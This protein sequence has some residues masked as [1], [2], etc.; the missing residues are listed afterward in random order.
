[1]Y[2]EG[3]SW[4]HNWQCCCFWIEVLPG[5]SIPTQVKFVTRRPSS[6]MYLYDMCAWK[7]E[8]LKIVLVTPNLWPFVTFCDI[9][10]CPTWS[11][12]QMCDQH[13]KR[14]DFVNFFNRDERSVTKTD[15]RLLLAHFA[16]AV[17]NSIG[18]NRKLWSRRC[19]HFTF[20]FRI[21][22]TLS[23]LYAGESKRL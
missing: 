6:Y 22:S 13:H 16:V 10:D 23:L 21:K 8:V 2:I 7:T 17:W 12:F 14:L 4:W 18:P 1:M 11:R 15:N 5:G 19:L 3:K 20:G 9:C